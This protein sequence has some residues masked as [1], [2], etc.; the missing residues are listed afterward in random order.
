M[1]ILCLSSHVILGGRGGGRG[2]RGRGRGGGRSRGGFRG[3]HVTPPHV[4]DLIIPTQVVPEG[5]EVE[6]KSMTSHNTRIK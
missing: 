2:M 6:D 5:L 1:F 4:H 3:I